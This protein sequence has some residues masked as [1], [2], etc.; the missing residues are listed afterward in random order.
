MGDNGVG[1]EQEYWDLAFRPFERLTSDGDGLGLGL[2]ASKR[3]LSRNHGGMHIQS[4][5]PGEGTVIQVL[6]PAVR[7]SDVIE[8][9]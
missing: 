9:V 6:L 7:P 8:L 3:L 4:S 5:V 1:I 2:A